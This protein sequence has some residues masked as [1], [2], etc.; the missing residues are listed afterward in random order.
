LLA[1]RHVVIRYMNSS[2]YIINDTNTTGNLVHTL[3][4]ISMKRA[5]ALCNS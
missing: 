4:L 3:T 1:K 5:S 2:L